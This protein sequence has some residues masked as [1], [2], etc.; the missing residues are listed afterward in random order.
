MKR[1]LG[2]AL[3][4]WDAIEGGKFQS[5]KALRERQGRG[6]GSQRKMMGSDG[7]SEDEIRMSQALANIAAEHGIKVEYLYDNVQ[8]LSIR[9][10]EQQIRFLESVKL[11]DVGYSQN[12][13]GEE[14]G[15]TGHEGMALAPAGRIAFVSYPRAIGYDLSL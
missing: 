9:L 11:S 5:E 7:Q 15:V 3:A 14:P 4:P 10:S 1:Q 8:A 6:E 12:M 13:L 2:M